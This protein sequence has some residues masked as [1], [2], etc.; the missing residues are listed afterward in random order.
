MSQTII[1]RVGKKRTIVIP[2]KIA[3]VLGIEEGSRLVLEV[4]DNNIVLKPLPN[5][6]HLSLYGEKIA[7]INLNELEE[8]SI[9]EQKKYLSKKQDLN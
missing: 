9:E 7:K 4:R 1:I 6:I 8:T 3:E 5:A 2:K